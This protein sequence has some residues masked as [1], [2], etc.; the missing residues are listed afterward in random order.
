[1]PLPLRVAREQVEEFFAGHGS[2]IAT[3]VLRAK[4]VS[5]QLDDVGAFRE[6]SDLVV[7][8]LT[9]FAT[10]VLGLALDPRLVCID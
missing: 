3:H 6:V 8:V 9:T 2:S 7:K 5:Q 10:A 4:T 1:M